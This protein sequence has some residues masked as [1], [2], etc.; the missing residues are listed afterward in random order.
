MRL[1]SDDIDNLKRLLES[2]QPTPE[3]LRYCIGPAINGNHAQMTRYILEQKYVSF[4]DYM[5][6]QALKVGTIQVLDALKE[7]G[8][9]NVNMSMAQIGPGISQAPE[10]AL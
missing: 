4:D 2:L 9:S 3:D 5:V 1:Y 8:W 7:F 10:T 6:Q